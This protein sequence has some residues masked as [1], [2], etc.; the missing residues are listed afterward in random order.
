MTYEVVQPTTHHVTTEMIQR[1]IHNYEIYHRIQ[2]VYETEILPA[3]HLVPDPNGDGLIEIPE[4]LLPDCTGA[5]QKWVIN[6]RLPVRNIDRKPVPRFT[7]PT[8]VDEKEYMTPEGYP[9]NETTIVY[10]PTLVDM[11]DYT[12]P[13]C[14]MNFSNG[15]AVYEEA[16]YSE[17]DANLALDAMPLRLK[18]TAQNANNLPSP[19]DSARLEL[20]ASRERHA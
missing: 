16:R 3:R 14:T 17:Q 7:E 15:I 5:N 13:V 9:R 12:G 4:S 8:T 20:S 6:E 19:P 11:S 18:G 1:E 2:P 10:P